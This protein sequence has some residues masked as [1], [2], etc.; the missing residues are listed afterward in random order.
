[1]LTWRHMKDL[2]FREGLSGTRYI[3]AAVNYILS[4]PETEPVLLTGDVYVEVGKRYGKTWTS[5]ERC[6]RHAIASC[7]S[8]EIHGKPLDVI[9]GL[10]QRCREGE[11]TA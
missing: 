9:M 2:G 7:E 6:V 3:R 11:F 10:V 1:M 5:V 8:A 4:K